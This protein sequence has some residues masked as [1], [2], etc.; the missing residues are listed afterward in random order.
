MKGL[1]LSPH[2]LWFN[3]CVLCLSGFKQVVSLPVRFEP[4]VTRMKER[5][6]AVECV[7]QHITSVR[8]SSARSVVRYCLRQIRRAGKMQSFYCQNGRC[9]H[10]ALCL[11]G[12]HTFCEIQSFCFSLNL[13]ILIYEACFIC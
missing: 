3:T 10:S 7:V 1:F 11:S 8:V 9:M 2:R 12:S 5:R 4:S 6:K 13:L